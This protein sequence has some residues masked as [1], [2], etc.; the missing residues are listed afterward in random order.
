MTCM[1]YAIARLLLQAALA[2]PPISTRRAIAIEK[3]Q[4]LVEPLGL[5]EASDDDTDTVK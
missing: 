4:E 5:A 3:A 2:I 1:V